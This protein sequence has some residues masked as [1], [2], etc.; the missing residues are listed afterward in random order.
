QELSQA[1]TQQAS[2]LEETAAALE[3]LS[4]MVAKNL[5][6]AKGTAQVSE[7]SKDSAAKGHSTVGQ[8]IVSMGDI[9]KSNDQI[10]E[11]V[12]VIGDI[13]AKTKV[14]N[15]IVFQTKLL[16]FNAS[17]EAARA[18]EQG[19]GFAVVAEEVGKL[20]QM[21]GNAAKEISG[22]LSESIHKVESI[23]HD[24]KGKVSSGEAWTQECGGILEEI[25]GNVSRVST[26]ASEI[27]LASDEQSRGVQEISKA[28][29]ELDQVTQKNATTSEKCAVAA[30]QLSQQ[31]QTLN[32]TVEQLVHVLSGHK[33][34]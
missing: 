28:M 33:S 11:I 9:R 3:E 29:T 15:D 13:D 8:M 4:S 22:L 19:R 16:S 27:S 21:S 6:N 2:S 5:D 24:S 10:S 7:E 17:V 1:T 26:M 30:E 25:V 14:I 18:G 32:K 23:V 31:S 12:K 34:A 20:A